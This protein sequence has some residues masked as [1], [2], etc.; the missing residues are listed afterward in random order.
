MTKFDKLLNETQNAF[1]VY[2]LNVC[3]D[4]LYHFF[5]FVYKGYR[6][7]VQRN[8]QGIDVNHPGEVIFTLHK[9]MPDGCSQT[10]VSYFENYEGIESVDELIADDKRLNCHSNIQALDI[11]KINSH[12]ARMISDIV[13]A[14]GGYREKDVLEN[15]HFCAP[16]ET[17]NDEHKV[18][19]IL[20]IMPESDG[21]YDGFQVDLVTQSI[22]G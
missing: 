5:S 3:N 1:G 2:M 12:T 9:I 15:A 4:A 11:A 8:E 19:D 7:Y 22:C 10:Q 6:V 13:K 14:H 21:Y 18:V 20:R 16:G 17:W